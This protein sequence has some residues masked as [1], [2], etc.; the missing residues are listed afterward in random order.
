VFAEP[1]NVRARALQADALEQLGYQAE[2]S[3]FRNAYLTGA[4]E[5]RH[6]APEPRAARRGGL[7]R[8]LTI[9]LIFDSIAIRLRSEEVGGKDV[10][11]NWRFSDIGEEWVLG[12]R[13]RALHAVRGRNDDAARATVTMTRAALIDVVAGESTFADLVGR[14]EV[15][16][17]GD[18]TALSEIFGHLD[19][20]AGGFPIVEP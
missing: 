14:G 16:V 12:L 7:L 13:H 10:T 8:A 19:T 5:L 3:T 6:G 11:I 17:G 9:E 4:H 15:S 20:F 2:S 18:P 1:A